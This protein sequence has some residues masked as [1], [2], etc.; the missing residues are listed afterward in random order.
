M[1]AYCWKMNNKLSRV[2]EIAKLLQS[3][4]QDGKNFH[5]TAAIKKRKIIA[6]AWNTYQ[7]PN[8]SHVFGE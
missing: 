5:V 1:E 6:I 2:I 3:E 8:L 7:E 4:K